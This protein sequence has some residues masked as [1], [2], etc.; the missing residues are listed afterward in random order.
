MKMRSIVQLFT[1]TSFFLAALGCTSPTPSKE[2]VGSPD[3]LVMHRTLKLLESNRELNTYRDEKNE[4]IKIREVHGLSEADARSYVRDQV[5]NILSLLSPAPEPYFGAPPKSPTCS[6]DQLPAATSKLDETF[7]SEIRHAYAT[8]NYVVGVCNSQLEVFKA[9]LEWLYCRH[10]Q[11]LFEIKTYYPA[12]QPWLVV[13]TAE[14]RPNE[15]Q[16]IPSG[17]KGNEQFGGQEQMFGY[18]LS[19]Y[20]DFEKKWHPVTVR[21]RKDTGELRFVYANDL[22][23]KALNAHQTNYPD[24]A[25]FAKIAAATETDSAFPSSLQPSKTR[26]YQFMVRNKSRHKD[27]DGW[28]YALFDSA[29]RTFDENPESM[30]K[31]C[32]ACHQLAASRGFV[33]SV[34]AELSPFLV[35]KTPDPPRPQTSV[36]FSDTSVDSLPKTLRDLI[37]R[38]FSAVRLLQGPMRVQLFQ[39]TLDEIRPLLAREAIQ[40]Q[41]P[42]A[43][44]SENNAR[45]SIVFVDRQMA[46]EPGQ[47]GLRAIFNVNLENKNQKREL[48]YCETR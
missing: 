33:F 47:I 7:F 3:G 40:T 27:T 39:G 24:G 35:D 11:K 28:G 2:S 15:A 29:G 14:C 20:R 12:D 9:Q 23:W 5:D 6:M 18:R 34:P 44:I 42:A 46:C 37:P 48:V 26:R 16:K 17:V 19:D 1:F 22:A 41:K 8:K 10:E 38:E 13:P 32:A 45:F 25:V 31:A 43:L 21:Y 30:V 4:V 36:Q